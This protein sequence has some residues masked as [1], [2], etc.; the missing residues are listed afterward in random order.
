MSYSTSEAFAILEDPRT[1]FGSVFYAICGPA[2]TRELTKTRRF[3]GHEECL[4]KM[5]SNGAY[6]P[7]VHVMFTSKTRWFPSIELE[8]VLDRDESEQCFY[9]SRIDPKGLEEDLK[10]MS[11]FI[12]DVKDLS[13]KYGIVII[14]ADHMI[15]EDKET[16]IEEE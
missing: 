15:T 2:N 1:P 8:T 12:E 10:V 4:I 14:T 3:T 9:A 6:P 16:T 11:E 13:D 7:E 5:S